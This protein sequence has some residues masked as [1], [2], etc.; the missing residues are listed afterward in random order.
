MEWC[1]TWGQA[2][3]TA[4]SPNTHMHAH[5]HPGATTQ[6]T[7]PGSET[8]PNFQHLQSGMHISL[9]LACKISDPKP[10]RAA[11]TGFCTPSISPLTDELCG[12][13]RTAGSGARIGKGVIS[14]SLPGCV[15]QFQY[16]KTHTF[17]SYAIMNFFP[18]DSRAS[19]WTN[20]NPWSMIWII[21]FLFQRNFMSLP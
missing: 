10:I 16:L 11:P 6:E 19:N 12:S 2:T 15:S 3:A 14:S 21:F 7:G 9:I 5:M 8:R 1:V 13:Q 4:P 17:S 18:L 20:Y